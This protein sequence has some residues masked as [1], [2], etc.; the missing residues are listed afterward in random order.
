MRHPFPALVL[1]A[2]GLVAFAPRVAAQG[3]APDLDAPLASAVTGIA[4][5]VKRQAQRDPLT[6]SSLT[7]PEPQF[8]LETTRGNGL[9]T[10]SLGLVSTSAA[11]ETTYGLAVSSPIGNSEDAEAR[12]IDLRG[13]ANGA[14]VKVSVTGS[15][16][17]KTFKARDVRDLCTRLGLAAVDCAAGKLETANP[18]AS[19]ALL[20]LAFLSVPVI[21]G[22][23][24]SYSRNTFAF[25]DAAGTRQDPVRHT[26]VEAEGSL[27]F[28]VNGR[29]DLVAVHVTFIDRYSG[30][31]S[32]TQFC[33]PLPN[34][35]VTRC[36]QATI[37][38][39]T[40]EKS[41]VTTAEYRWQKR[42]PGGL[43]FAV[44]PK[45]Q[46]SA[47]FDGGD[48]LTSVEVPLYVFQQKPTDAVA[49]PKMNGGLSA[50]WRSDSGFQAGVFIGATFSLFKL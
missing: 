24:F 13:L 28:L 46:W 8:T 34:S 31:S 18:E 45:V 7:L 20:D 27:G 30:S 4:T 47:G 25:F 19:Q 26:S 49:A 6:R 42:G 36:D 15:R 44:A 11:G 48:D 10:G 32:K 1:S 21:Y 33:R 41:L 35:T 39:P 12:P 3:P 2:I 17:F 29:R 50:G 9:A 5:S 23:S 43:P 14:T 37:G 22:G 38:A 40:H 16:L